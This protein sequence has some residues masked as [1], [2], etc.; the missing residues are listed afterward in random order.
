MRAGFSETR[1]KQTFVEFGQAFRAMSPAL[2]AT[3]SLILDRKLRHG[4]NP[5]LNMCAANAIIERDAAG[6]RRSG[7]AEEL[8]AW[9]RWR[10]RS[11]L[12][13]RRGRRRSIRPL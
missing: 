7:R 6:C 9:W 11:A 1:L 13:R 12:R 10:W 2:R 8:T 5:I 3:E 4:G